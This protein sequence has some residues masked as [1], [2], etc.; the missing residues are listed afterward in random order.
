VSFV[1]FVVDDI[2][3]MD[4]KRNQMNNRGSYGI[5]KKIIR[6]LF[7]SSVIFSMSCASSHALTF[8]D[9]LG[10]TVTLQTEPKRIVSMAPSITEILYFLGLG[11]RV[12]GVT[13]FSYFPP[14]AVKKPKIGSY[15]NLNV[16]RIVSLNPDLAI[17]TADG[18]EPFTVKMLD[19]AGIPVYIVNPRKVRD[20][21]KSIADL[22]R[23][24]GVGDKAEVL[25]RGLAER[26][27]KVSLKTTGLKRPL[28]FLQINIR[29]MMTVN[30]KTFHHNVIKLAGGENMTGDEPITYPRISMEEVISRK[31]EVIVISS[32]ERGGKF[33]RARKEWMK[34]PVIPAVRSGRVHLIDSDLLDRPSPRIVNGLEQMARVIHPEVEWDK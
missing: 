34:W 29:P 27:N 6:C 19:E 18:N 5:R 24:C 23:I 33:E 1:L 28:V 7:V 25:S 17:G 11:D 30:H 12:V 15:I 31:P 32:M 4:S 26:V 8:K 2:F 13:Q 3:K 9:A 10:R 22:G 16:E 20:V 21:I 14:E